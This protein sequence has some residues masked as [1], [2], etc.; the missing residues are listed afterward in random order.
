MRRVSSAAALLLSLLVHALTL[1]FIVL[2]CWIIWMN[3]HLAAFWLVGSVLIGIGVLLLPRARRLPAD[4]EPLGRSAA[5]ELYATAERVA[6]A[7]GMTPPAVLA[8]RD[9]A[10]TT[11]VMRAGR[12][13]VLLIGLPPWLVSS[14]R[15]RVV[16]LARAYASEPDDGRIVGGAL[17]TLAVW[18]ESLLQG[19]EAPGRSDV[20]TRI[21]AAVGSVGAPSGAYSGMGSMGRGLGRVIGVPV[22]FLEWA[23][24]RLVQAS[25]GDTASEELQRVRRVATDADLADL[26]D[27]LRDGRYLAPV[28]AAALRGATATEIR[29][30]ATTTTATTAPAADLL[31][32]DASGRIDDELSGHFTRAIKGF[33]LIS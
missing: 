4:A 18:R 7:M 22:L 14:A 31:T 27:L 16:L 20:Y 9:L 15:Q 3:A 10:V 25:R 21:G 6:R 29:A 19:E 8:V 33:G 5:P 2:G 12:R 17:T 23:L 24:T 1:A 13:R 11:E 28:Q 30:S 26:D 32:A